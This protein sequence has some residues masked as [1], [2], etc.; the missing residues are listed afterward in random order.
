MNEHCLLMFVGYFLQSF[1]LD[2]V[3]E[4]TFLIEKVQ[5][6]DIKMELIFPLFN[7][8]NIYDYHN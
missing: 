1:F 3:F 6:T 7:A 5:Y 4:G 8:K 2:F